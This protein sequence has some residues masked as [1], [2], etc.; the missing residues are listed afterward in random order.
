MVDPPSV[1]LERAH[2]QKV[3]LLLKD[4]R[5]LTGRLLGCDEHLNMVLDDAEEMTKEIARRLGR[6]VLRGSNV[7]TVNVAGGAPARSM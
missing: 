2:D 4:G 1:T 7:V 5:T 3:L 6:V